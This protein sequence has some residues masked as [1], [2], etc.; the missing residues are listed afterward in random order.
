VH[1]FQIVQTAADR[2]ML[3]FDPSDN[4]GRRAA[5]RAAEGALRR[6]L[7]QQSL[8]NVRVGLDQRRPL[9]DR[10]SGKFKEVIVAMET[11][12]AISIRGGG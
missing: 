11:P 5:W 2:L 6:Y 10:R 4:N 9:A 1:R 3:R 8:P 7:D 12:G